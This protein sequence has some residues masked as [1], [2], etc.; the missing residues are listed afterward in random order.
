MDGTGT[1]AGAYLFEHKGVCPVCEADTTF[2]AEGPY[3][4]GTLK[5]ISCDSVPR[6]RAVVAVLAKYFPNWRS[7]DIHEGSP[8]LRRV[9]RKLAEECKGYIGSHYDTSVPFGCIGPSHGLRSEN[10]E[11]QTFAD[12][13]FD[14]VITQD[15]FEHLFRP[16][17]AI[18]EVARTLRQGGAHICT[19][20]IV[21]KNN[22]SMRRAEKVGDQIRNI[23]PAHYH[24]NPI[25]PNGSLVTIGWGYDIAAYFFRHADLTVTIIDIDNIDMGIRA[26]LNEVLVCRKLGIPSL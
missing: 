1:P 17:L 5:C 22:P 4:R 26:D 7:M 2:R 18:K 12:N 16:D 25:D 13:S 20:P 15:V 19:V 8:S 14:I 23:E 11:A 24:G 21:R 6:E 10:L 3:F 9:S